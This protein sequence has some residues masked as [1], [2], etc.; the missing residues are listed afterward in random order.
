MR[1]LFKL[2]HGQLLKSSLGPDIALIR[3]MIK[4]FGDHKFRWT[5]VVPSDPRLELLG[6]GSLFKSNSNK[7]RGLKMQPRF[8]LSPEPL[9][10]SGLGRL[11]RYGT[12][13]KT[14][15][16]GPEQ[17]HPSSDPRLE[18]PADGAII[19]ACMLSQVSN[20]LSFLF[21]R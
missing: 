6:E 18:W 16:G 20:C 3:C 2:S 9:L 17:K 8:E 15:S 19:Q 7:C 10:K 5:E 1:L 4:I 21:N 11:A 13:Q 12:H 14:I